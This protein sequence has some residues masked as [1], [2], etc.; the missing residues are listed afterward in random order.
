MDILQ[1]HQADAF[2]TVCYK[3]GS[4]DHT[5]DK[6]LPPNEAKI[7]KANEACTKSIAEGCASG[8]RSCVHRR[9]GGRGGGGKDCTNTLGKWGAKGGP[10]TPGTNKSSSDGIKKR[11]GIMDDDLEAVLM[12]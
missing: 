6:C 11:N 2:V 3:C 4:P 9:G 5:S 7:M 1:S 10:A 12:E 8:G